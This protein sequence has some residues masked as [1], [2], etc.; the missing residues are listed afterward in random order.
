MITRW[1]GLDRTWTGWCRSRAAWRQTGAGLSDWLSGS[2]TRIW[3]ARIS[4]WTVGVTRRAYRIVWTTRMSG[5]WAGISRIGRWVTTWIG[6][7][8]RLTRCRRVTIS[9][10][11]MVTT[12]ITWVTW[13]RRITSRIS[14]SRRISTR[15]SGRGRIPVG[16]ILARSRTSGRI[17]GWA[18]CR[19]KT[20]MMGGARM[21]PTTRVRGLCSRVMTRVMWRIRRLMMSCL[22]VVVRRVYTRGGIYLA[23]GGVLMTGYSN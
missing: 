20:W 14:S 2:G 11:I 10:F 7:V 17:P 5:C 9:W 3:S 15:V 13:G 19:V 6:W 8:T 22:L 21:V 4:G 12:G 16:F 1:T 18:V 23:G